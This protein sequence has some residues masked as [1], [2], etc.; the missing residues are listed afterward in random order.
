MSVSSPVSR[1]STTLR[2]IDRMRPP[3]CRT[4]AS[5]VYPRMILRIAAGEK[6]SGAGLSPARRIS[7]GIR[8]SAAMTA[9]SASP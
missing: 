3:S 7:A 4:P 2:Q 9:F 5:L 8:C 6:L 1:P